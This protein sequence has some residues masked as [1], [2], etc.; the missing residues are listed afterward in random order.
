MGY[1]DILKRAWNLVWRYRALWIFG[2]LLALTTVSGFYFVG[3][4]DPDDYHSEIQVKLTEDAIIYLPGEGLRVDL[5]KPG[6]LYV[7]VAEG[8]SWRELGELTDLFEWEP[9]GD[10]LPDEVWAILIAIGSV[11]ALVIVFGGIARYVSEASLIHMVNSTEE[12]GDTVSMKRGFRLGFSRTAWRL[13]LIDLLVQVPVKVALIALFAL[14]LLPL[15]L[16]AVGSTAAGVVG[17]LFA[18]GLFFLLVVLSIVASAAL[19]LLLQV[20]RRAC[21]M[22][23]L[24]ALAAIRRGTAMVRGNPKQVVSVWAIWIATR[25]LWMVAMVPLLIVLSPIILMFLVAG[26]VLGGLPAVTIGAILSIFFTSA[27][28]WVIGAIVGLPILLLITLL[29]TLFFSGLVEVFKSSTWTLAYRQLLAVENPASAS[30][31][32]PGAPGLEPAPAA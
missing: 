5:T 13:F 7:E 26:L 2:M 25:L 9:W 16:W 6:G 20:C 32:A 23:G 8:S 4:L 29:P 22:E 21:A 10:T 30:V 19:S 11:L 18:T 31:P 14:A 15:G 17:T 12:T 3:D 27:V 1:V 28:P 24:G